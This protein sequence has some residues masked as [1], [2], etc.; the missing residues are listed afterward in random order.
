[1]SNDMVIPNDLVQKKLNE[2]HEIRPFPA[3]VS[4]LLTAIKDPDADAGMFEKIIEQDAGLSTRI[5]R[6]VNSPVYGY[7]KEIHSIRQS[8][9]LIGQN[10]L[11][12]LALTYAGTAIVSSQADAGN[13]GKSLW[14][15]SLGCATVARQGCW[16]CAA[17]PR[18]RY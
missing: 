6:M 2:G 11:K 15:H 17:S 14:E 3:A 1:M 10:R 13:A 8:V 12:S 16:A 7:S 9:T 5:L 18:S 4:Q